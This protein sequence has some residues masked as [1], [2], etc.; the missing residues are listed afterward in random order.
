MHDILIWLD[1][2]PILWPVFIFCARICDVTIGTIRTICVVRGYRLVAAVLGFFEVTIW[3][4][5]VSGVLLRLDR[6]YNVVS[7]GL[8]FA[9]G[10]AVGMWVEQK[11]ALGMQAIMLIS[12]GHSAAVT[13]ALRFAG[14]PVTEVK[15]HGRDGDVSVAY[16]VTHRRDTAVAIQ[17]ARR[18][19]PAV[20]TT[21]NDVRTRNVH[22]Y[23]DAVPPTG[24]RAILKRK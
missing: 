17:I 14:F 21:V 9:T 20:F 23:R 16:V 8:G 19:D 11:L 1:Q 22:V 3:I 2:H 13:E 7:Y 5:A 4:T 12:Q 24:W 18:I 10:N 6:W 15:G